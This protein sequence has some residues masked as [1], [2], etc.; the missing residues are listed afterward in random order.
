MPTYIWVRDES[1]GHCYDAD[2]RT[3]RP[4]MTPVEDYPPN[5]GPS[6][7]PR[8]PKHFV[9]KDGAPASKTRASKTTPPAD[10]ATT[11]TP[12]GTES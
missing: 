10:S 8:R 2:E 12:E 4:G 1:T 5:F 9:A 11:T 6:A 7:R 3:L